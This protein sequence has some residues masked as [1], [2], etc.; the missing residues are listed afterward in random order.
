[1]PG[2]Y[3]ATEAGATPVAGRAATMAGMDDPDGDPRTGTEPHPR[4][5][6]PRAAAVRPLPLGGDRRRDRCP[7]R[8]AGLRRGA[9]PR[10]RVRGP[11]RHRPGRPHHDPRWRRAR[12]GR[13]RRRRGGGRL[14][15]GDGA[16]ARRRHD[17]HAQ[18]GAAGW[19]SVSP[20][21]VSSSAR[22]AC[23]CSPGPRAASCRSLD[24][25]G[26]TF[27]PLVPLQV[28]AAAVW[29]P[30][31]PPDD[32]RHHVPPP[33]RGRPRRHRRPGGRLVGRPAPAR[34]PAPAVVPAL[35]R[36]VLDRR[37]RV[38]V[39]SSRSSSGSSARTTRPRRTSTWSASARTTGGP[40]SGAL[41]TSG[42]SPTSQAR[43]VRRVRAI[44][45]PG[46]RTSVAFHTR[47]GLPPV[48]RPRH[49]EPLRHARL[50]R[51]RRPRR[52]PGRL[53]PRTSTSR[54]P[55]VEAASRS[56][57][58][59]PGVSCSCSSRPKRAG[60][61][62]SG[63]SVQP[64]TEERLALGVDEDVRPPERV[65]DELEPLGRDR[66]RVAPD[67]HEVVEDLVVRP[68]V[69]VAQERGV[70]PDGE[71]GP[72]AGASRA[73]ERSAASRA[74]AG[75]SADRPA[76]PSRRARRAGPRR[77]SS[78]AANRAPSVREAL[79]DQALGRVDEQD[80]GLQPALR[81]DQ[82][83]LLPG[84]LEVVARV[85]LV[86]DRVR[87]GPAARTGRSVLMST[88]DR[89]PPSNQL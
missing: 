27:G 37:G 56:A 16:P 25:L 75:S 40:G 68:A 39:A 78:G 80:R 73:T 35:H 53:R 20:S 87:G 79:A 66:R 61:S 17:A 32:D 58:M 45:W 69:G 74:A 48:R 3:R 81:V 47:D 51:L 26:Q 1:M 41:C 83:R 63:T 77:S 55:P 65:L 23:G 85:R 28:V 44:T 8:R 72:A 33:G 9:G 71:R 7:T 86:G 60:R 10:D 4:G 2:V 19:R 49:A 38:R 15:R 21:A 46:N 59:A 54:Q 64:A 31:G 42:S 14:G 82:V 84:V 22:S 11:R 89:R 18:V 29:P 52:G 62:A 43:G 50:P 36:D 24:Y 57:A 30:R 6:S 34:P 88:R 76:R 5:A 67:R 12:L 13:A 70:A